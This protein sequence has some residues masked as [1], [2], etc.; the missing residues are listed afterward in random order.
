MLKTVNVIADVDAEKFKKNVG[1]A[2][3]IMQNDSF[4]VE[5]QYTTEIQLDGKLLMTAMLLGR[6]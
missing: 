3:E 1:T 5:V 4:K 6:G 2:I